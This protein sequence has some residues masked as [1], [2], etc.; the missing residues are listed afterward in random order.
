MKNEKMNP[1]V[2]ILFLVVL[3]HYFVIDKVVIS[4]MVLLEGDEYHRGNNELLNI[5][6]LNYYLKKYQ[7]WG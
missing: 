7:P 3:L 5:V 6:S 1:S 4:E 2:Q